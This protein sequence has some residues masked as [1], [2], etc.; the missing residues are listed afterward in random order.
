MIKMLAKVSQDLQ[1]NRHF[2]ALNKTIE[3]SSSQDC[4]VPLHELSSYIVST[5]EDSLIN[6]KEFLKSKRKEFFLFAR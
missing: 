2:Q 4:T 1:R 5:I 3:M 6:G